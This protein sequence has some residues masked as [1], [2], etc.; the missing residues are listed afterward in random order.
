MPVAS[1]PLAMLGYRQRTSPG[2][3][4]AGDMKLE[5]PFSLALALR[6]GLVFLVLHVLGNLAQ[7]EFGD[8]G[9][10]FVSVVGGLMSS[11]SAV[12]AAGTLA[13]HGAL[14]DAVAGTG[15]VL[16]SFTSIVFSLS[17]VLRSRARALIRKVAAAM[18]VVI[19]AGALGLVLARFLPALMPAALRG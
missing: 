9:F 4:R 11:A 6:Y 16:A 8:V 17:F 12:A 14:P 7:R 10:Y 15:A 19:V 1:A 2:V 13:S 3:A 18:L 5:L